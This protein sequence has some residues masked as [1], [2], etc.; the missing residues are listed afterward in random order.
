MQELL[1]TP[2]YPEV[3]EQVSS[4]ALEFWNQLIE[5]VEELI[6]EYGQDDDIIE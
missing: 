2:G 6:Q 5:Y 1:Q 3:D 4:Q